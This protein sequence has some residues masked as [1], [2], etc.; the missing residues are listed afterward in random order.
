MTFAGDLGPPLSGV[1]KRLD[2]AQLR[3]RVADNQ[4]VNAATIMPSYYRVEGLQRVAP[5][6]RGK[7]ILTAQEIED[8]VAYLAT[9]Q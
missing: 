7:P 9:L 5:A 8:I 4:R 3:L 1:G 2:T 6:Y